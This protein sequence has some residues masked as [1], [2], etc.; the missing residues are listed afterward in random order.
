MGGSASNIDPSKYNI[1]DIELKTIKG[2]PTTL[3]EYQGK[4]LLIVNT[5]SK[6]GFTPQFKTLEEL[7]LKYK[8]QGLV[9]LG[10]PSNDF[11]HQDPNGNDEIEQFCS[12]NYGV[13]FPLFEKSIV[14][15]C[16][17]QNLLFAYLTNP[18]TNPEFS[19]KIS[20]NFNK[21]LISR[22]GKILN[23]FGSSTDPMTEEVIK[24]VEAAIAETAEAPVAAPAEE[25][26]AENNAEPEAATPAE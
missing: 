6:C 2:Q 12:L 11:L 20:W 15:I 25:K 26:P 4:V 23:R 16:D 8:D 5:A 19:G 17:E 10:F 14:K 9:I 21:F 24:A 13:T 3:R 7:Y 1:Y 22:N 18:A